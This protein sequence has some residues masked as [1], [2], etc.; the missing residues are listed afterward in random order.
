M[1]DSGST[2]VRFERREMSIA[3]PMKADHSNVQAIIG[4]EDLA[5]ALYR[6]S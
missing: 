5:M 4:T 1:Q 3:S 2:A 6:S